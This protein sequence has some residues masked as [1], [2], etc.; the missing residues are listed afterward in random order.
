MTVV[1]NHRL[2]EP[3]W[4][5][6]ASSDVP[7]AR[8]FYTALF[9]WTADEGGGEYGG[10]ITF[11]RDGH[12]VAG[13][14]AVMGDEKPNSWLTYLLVRGLLTRRPAQVIIGLVVLIVY[15]GMIWGVLPGADGI[16]W[17]AHL[18]GAIGGIL[19]AWLLHRRRQR[20]ATPLTS[21]Y[22]RHG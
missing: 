15:G 16:S 8:D 10:Y 18:G 21:T 3:C 4:V 14:G 13:L 19:A 22:V 6:Y 12:A 9:G 17:Q 2:G 5:D 11:R 7:R 1:T 20:A